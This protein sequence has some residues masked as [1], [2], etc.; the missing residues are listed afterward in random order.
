M[1]STKLL[2]MDDFDKVHCA[3]IVE[4]IVLENGKDIVYLDQTVFYP[5]G[6][7]QPYDRGVIRSAQGEFVVE[8]VRFVD[9][10]VKHIGFFKHGTFQPS[11]SVEC[12]VDQER[13]ALN[14]RLHS[15]GHL[16]DLAV[17]ELNL[18]WVP[19]KGFHFPEG[20]Y[21]E[22]EVASNDFDKEDIKKRLE[23]ICNRLI[24]DGNAT[25]LVFMSKDEM[26]KVCKNVPDFIPNDKPAR[27]VMYGTIGIPC[28]GTHVKNSAEVK[29]MNIRKIKV[30]G[31]RVKVAYEI[32]Q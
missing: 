25:T 2:Y 22:Y 12:I 26:K 15:A 18:P 20:P 10:L 31:N 17:Q 8:E 28:G 1:H 13:R 29:A 11:D 6:G 23:E 32:Q 16:V 4:N 19:A 24:Q 7:G 14:T 30:E 3:A 5:Q 27:I 21:V 9:G